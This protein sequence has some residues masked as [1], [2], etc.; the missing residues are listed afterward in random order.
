MSFSIHTD[1]DSL[2]SQ[3]DEDRVSLDSS[4]NTYNSS[5][6]EMN[7]V[8]T[9]LS[10]LVGE[11]Q[12]IASSL[13]TIPVID[14]GTTGDNPSGLMGGVQS[15]FNGQGSMEG[16]IDGIEDEINQI[17]SLWDSLK[18]SIT[19]LGGQ[20]TG[21]NVVPQN[22]AWGQ[23]SSGGIGYAG[24]FGNHDA[25]IGVSISVTDSLLTSV[26]SF[27]LDLNSSMNQLNVH[28]KNLRSAIKAIRESSLSVVLSTKGLKT[29]L[30]GVVDAIV[31][32]LNF[33]QGFTLANLTSLLKA[34]VKLALS[35][36]LMQYLMYLID[37][38]I[39]LE[40]TLM[41]ASRAADSIQNSVDRVA[42]KLGFPQ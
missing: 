19:T 24:G 31:R 32:I 5:V 21:S 33:V 10:T 11:L 26:E 25:S 38:L 13:T 41:S 28:V 2:K 8:T 42:G 12:T 39:E 1:L 17:D 37:W 30:G 18:G 22:H 15:M 3:W 27:I 14:L 20:I 36:M 35:T 9:L 23:G 29:L 4:L 16:S 6:S 7:G 40:S 34:I